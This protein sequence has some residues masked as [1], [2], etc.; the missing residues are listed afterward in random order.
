LK[1]EYV[2]S[3]SETVYS[4]TTVSTEHSDISNDDFDIR[5]KAVTITRQNGLI[6]NDTFYCEK[7]KIFRKQN[8]C[9]QCDNRLFTSQDF[10]SD[11]ELRMDSDYGS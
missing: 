3:D 9:D 8:H 2:L 6:R 4:E 1:R 7:C 10:E 11:D 5:N